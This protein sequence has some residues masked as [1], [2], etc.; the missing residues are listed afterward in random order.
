MAPLQ[1][2]IPNAAPTSLLRTSSLG[3]PMHPQWV[4]SQTQVY[5]PLHYV[6]GMPQSKLRLLSLLRSVL[7]DVV[8][9]VSDL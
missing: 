9:L 5:T 1:G 2:A 7:S 4:P 3:T 6:S 8:H